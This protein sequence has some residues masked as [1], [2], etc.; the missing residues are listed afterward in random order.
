MKLF[1]IFAAAATAQSL[2]NDT[3]M[4]GADASASSELRN[5][6]KADKATKQKT[7]TEE[8]EKGEQEKKAAK[9]QAKKGK[10]KNKEKNETQEERR[11]SL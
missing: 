5:K 10:D 7:G 9:T 3:R 1:A 2:A 11:G 8:T 4:Y 6:E